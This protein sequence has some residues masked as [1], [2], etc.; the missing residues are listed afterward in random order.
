MPNRIIRSII[1][2]QNILAMPGSAT[3]FEAAQRMA[4][5]RVGSVLVLAGE[6]L[7]GIFTER[8]ALNRV[9]ATGADPKK[10]RIDAVMTAN[11]QTVHPDKPLRDA[12]H[13]MFE[14]GFRHV[15]V[16]EAG[17]PLGMISAR[18]ALGVEMVSFEKEVQ[19]RDDLAERL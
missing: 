6:Q 12:L 3:V 2:S 10:T 8:D 18:D 16:V 14:G 7:A 1:A 17:R 9:L 19:L 13:M 11:P 4:A 5:E 15:P